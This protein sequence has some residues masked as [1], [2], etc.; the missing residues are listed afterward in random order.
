MKNLLLVL[1]VLP[2]IGF[3]QRV[4][5]SGNCVNGQG[6]CTWPS[7]DKYVGEF[8]NENRTGQGTYTWADGDKYVGEFKDGKKNGQGTLTYADGTIKKGL[9]ENDRFLAIK[10][11]FFSDETSAVHIC[12]WCNIKYNSKG[13]LVDKQY[14]IEAVGDFMDTKRTSIYASGYHWFCSRKCASEYL[15]SLD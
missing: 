9:W 6:T 2:M 14:K 4:C 15:L 8:V 3:G 12:E 1:L 11:S 13:Y 7:G 10:G 5:I